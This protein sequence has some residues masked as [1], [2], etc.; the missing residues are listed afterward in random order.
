[1]NSKTPQASESPTFQARSSSEP[2]TRYEEGLR[3]LQERQF[4]QASEIF[5]ELLA[6]YPDEKELNE[7]VRVHLAV[8]D[9]HLHRAS[10]EELNKE[11]HLFAG[12]LALNAGEPVTAIEHLHSVVAEDNTNDSA[13]YML[14]VAH[15][16]NND[17]ENALGY[18]QQAVRF[19]PENRLL[20]LQDEDLESLLKD[21]SNRVVLDEIGSTADVRQ[22]E[23]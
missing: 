18:L 9:R 17:A 1:L 15:A 16:L 13:L 22:S 23:T 6:N 2:I 11:E 20:A 10:F 21:E 8:C 7:R 14:A 19:N 12:T 4:K 3:L 5:N